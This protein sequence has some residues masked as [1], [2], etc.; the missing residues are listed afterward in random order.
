MALLSR[1]PPPGALVLPAQIRH[2]AVGHFP[3]LPPQSCNWLQDPG[4]IFLLSLFFGYFLR[5]HYVFKTHLLSIYISIKKF[6]LNYFT[7]QLEEFAKKTSLFYFK[8]LRANLPSH[9][10]FN[11][12]VKKRVNYIPKYEKGWQIQSIPFRGAALLKLWESKGCIITRFTFPHSILLNAREWHG[13]IGHP[14]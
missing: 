3:P 6:P 2:Q 5:W 12:R 13:K 10:Q 9:T 1:Q 8:M 11:T 4:F 7:K 14:F